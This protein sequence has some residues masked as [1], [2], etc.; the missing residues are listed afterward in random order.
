[1]GTML[2]DPQPV[3]QPCRSTTAGWPH[4]ADRAVEVALEA[5]PAV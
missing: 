2:T 1:L 5:R 3:H 4:R